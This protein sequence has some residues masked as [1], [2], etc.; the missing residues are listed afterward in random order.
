MGSTSIRYSSELMQNYL[1]AEVLSAEEGFEALQTTTG[2]SLLFSIGSDGAFYLTRETPGQRNGWRRTNLSS[3]VAAR[4]FPNQTDLRC[5]AF[6][7]SQSRKQNHTQIHVAMVLRAADGDHLYLSLENS[8]VDSEWETP[9][10][11]AAVPFD[12]PN[13]A[14]SEVRIHQV[15]V[16]EA[17]DAEYIVVDVS[18]DPSAGSALVRRYYIDPHHDGGYAWHSHDISIDLRADRYHTCLGR[19]ARQRV[20]GFYTTGQVGER[21]Q[22]IYQPLYNVYNRNQQPPTSVLELPQNRLPD[23]ISSLRAE[24]NSTTLFAMADDRLF[25]FDS[26]DQDNGAVAVELV[27]HELFR[28]VRQLFTDSN[29]GEV[30]VWGLNGNN[31]VFYT[32]RTADGVWSRPARVLTGVE[33]V[34]PCLDRVRGALTFFA[35]T[36]QNRLTKATKSPA[37]SMWSFQSITLPA[38]DVSTKARAFPAYTTRV[39]VTGEDGQPA[40]GQTVQL[41]ATNIAGVYINYLYYLVGPEAIEVQTDATGALTIVE[42]VSSPTGTRLVVSR[43]DAQVQINPMDNA[44]SKAT[45]LTS[46]EQLRQARITHAD[47]STRPL[48]PATVT[49]EDLASVATGNQRLARAY[50]SAEPTLATLTRASH[51]H[52]ASAYGA[53]PHTVR[54]QT[55]VALPAG[56]VESF[57][58]DAGDFF[59]WLAGEIE[60]GIEHAI[61]VVEDAATGLWHFVAEVAGQTYACVLDCVEAVVS[62]VEWLYTVIKTAV[63]DLLKYLEYLFDWADIKRTQQVIHNLA[64]IFLDHQTNQIHDLKNDLDE[65][66]EQAKKSLADWAG[67]PDWSGLGEDA[68]ATPASHS[69]PTTGQSAPETLLAHHFQHNAASAVTP[70]A[71]AKAPAAPSAAIEA[72]LDALN[73]EADSIGDTIGRLRDIAEHATTMSLVDL[74]KSIVETIADLALDSAKNILDPLLEALY[75]LVAAAVQALDTPIHIPVLSDILGELGVPQF[76]LLELL[77]WIAAVPATIMHKAAT[78]S[79]P[80]PAGAET[81]FLINAPDLRTVQKAMRGNADPAPSGE[82]SLPAAVIAVELPQVSDRAADAIHITGHAVSGFCALNSALISSIEAADP[83]PDSPWG[84]PS[85]VLALLGGVS[86]GVANFLVPKDPIQSPVFAWTSN[87]TLAVR[88]ACIITFSGPAQTKFATKASLKF[89]HVENSRGVGAVIDAAI[90]FP[91]LA[92]SAWRFYELA[93][94]PA[95]ATRSTA[96]VDETSALTAYLARIAYAVAVNTKGNPEVQA[97]AIATLAVANVCTGGL[98]FAETLIH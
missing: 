88:I 51:L 96:I 32:R 83:N 46:P 36:G 77:C 80:F 54:L 84:K 22:F 56:G 48:I 65:M 70:T 20:D 50:A 21:T 98:Q 52:S 94:R 72:L 19:K 75:E 27:R 18:R 29:G 93:R 30:V 5:S 34:A 47:G 16:S 28:S 26:T 2:A 81:E 73:S 15:L 89:L 4:D 91:A 40:S 8:G 78:K 64:K 55:T 62:A 6:S 82:A 57:L 45:G 43:E 66:I 24:D 13:H 85:A 92:C 3:D 68:H 11:W 44:F 74:L 35:H 97:V 7:T 1:Q 69:T 41:Q 76:S 60:A 31:E 90:I 12:D 14:L 42:P 39:T 71:Q 17:T 79:A 67:T 49:N 95:G 9:P 10:E 33:R 61:E 86:S 63:Q 38:M 53:A 37:T 25:E 23:A 59:V 87:L 58:V